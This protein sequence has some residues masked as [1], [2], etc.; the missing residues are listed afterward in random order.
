[1][2]GICKCLPAKQIFSAFHCTAQDSL[3]PLAT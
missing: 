2:L 1:M 3:Y